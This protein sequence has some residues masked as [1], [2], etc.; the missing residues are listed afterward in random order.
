MAT[1]SVPP[2]SEAAPA[3]RH[4]YF[5]DWGFISQF[6]LCGILTV[7]TLVTVWLSWR[8]P[9]AVDAPLMQYAA[10]LM[11][12]GKVLY[13]DIIDMNGIG[14]P[15]S[16][17]LEIHLLGY[18]DLGWRIY[19]LL[20]IALG[21]IGIFFICR[22]L[23]RV[24]VIFSTCLFALTHI[25][26]G[27]REL[28]QRDFQMV[29][30]E[31][32]GAG[33][34]LQGFRTRKPG[35]FV[36]SGAA[37]MLGASIKP[38]G[39]LYVAL[40]LLYTIAVIVSERSRKWTWLLSFIAGAAVPCMLAA[41]YLIYNGAWHAFIEINGT[42]LPLYSQL[43][44]GSLTK[45]LRNFNNF[46][47]PLL[48][49]IIASGLLLTQKREGWLNKES[50]LVLLGGFCG[51]VCFFGQ[52]KG[53]DYQLDP[54]LA[55]ATVWCG[56]SVAALIQDRRAVIR[57]ALSFALVLWLIVWI[58]RFIRQTSHGSAS[59][60]V[61]DPR[62]VHFLE[63]EISKLRAEGRNNGIQ[64]MDTVQG[65]ALALY[66]LKLVQST[67]F[68]YDF[69]FYRFSSQPYIQRLRLRF[70]KELDATRPDLL[71][72]SNQ[73]WPDP[74]LGYNRIDQWPEFRNFLDTNYKLE[75]QLL[76]YR[77]YVHR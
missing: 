9:L 77:I 67:S 39:L 10:F 76:G 55:F 65:A 12:H 69:Y 50:R 60:V 29:A 2:P 44:R 72:I 41:A 28:G 3:H 49:L 46:I 14:A 53:W 30:L 17:R 64:M 18:S 26:L 74:E 75:K 25:R 43:G 59:L 35:W 24:G 52:A 5:K 8:W 38:P 21:S 40:F 56:I 66:D 54:F 11:D 47:Q 58:P 42:F 48:L 13:R 7:T 36:A 31:L 22:P 73:S 63:A 34:L 6:L 61:Y 57:L 32:L 15:F 51:L 37:A 27:A 1:V 4:A 68:L 70:L 19:D 33:F 71:V 16:S 20:F 45:L 23:G 62:Y